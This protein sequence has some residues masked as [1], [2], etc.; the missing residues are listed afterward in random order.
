M[1]TLRLTAAILIAALVTGC[2]LEGEMMPSASV[3]SVSMKT[4]P[5]PAVNAVTPGRS[6]KADV[7]ASLGATTTVRF[8]SG[9]EVWVYRLPN[10]RTGEYVILFSPSGI[11]AKTR[12]R[13]DTGRG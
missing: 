6:T 4:L 8:D 2:A 7:L 11:V 12:V 13:P 9:Y 1:I 5:P 10:T 3:T